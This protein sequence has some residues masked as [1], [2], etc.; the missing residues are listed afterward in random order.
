MHASGLTLR[1][2]ASGRIVVR[3]P[4]WFGPDGS[5]KAF[6][7]RTFAADAVS[8][9]ALNPKQFEAEISIAPERLRDLASVYSTLPR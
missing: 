4:G 9:V 3:N 5:T 7:R 1:Q 6:V 8:C 2:I